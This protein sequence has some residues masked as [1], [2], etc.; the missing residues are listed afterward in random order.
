M[1]TVIVTQGGKG[2][3][4]LLTLLWRNINF[5]LI[6]LL[7]YKRSEYVLQTFE[8]LKGVLGDF[9]FSRL[10]EVIL[11]DYAEENTMPKYFSGSAKHKIF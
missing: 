6:Y 4:G 7:P 10:F 9:E 11:T 3:K 2:G 5:M 1:D 8:M